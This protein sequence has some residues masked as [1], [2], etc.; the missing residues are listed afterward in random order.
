V[1]AATVVLAGTS[2]EPAQTIVDAAAGECGKERMNL[3][4][5]LE[6]HGVTKSYEFVD[7]LVKDLRP[8]PWRLS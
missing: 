7:G 2:N 8:G 3:A 5:A 4:S 6:R 1:N